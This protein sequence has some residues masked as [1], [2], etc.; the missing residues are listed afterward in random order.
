MQSSFVT[1]AF[2]AALMLSLA[3]KLWLATRQVRHVAT[4]RDRVPAAF[5]GS[6][7][8]QAHQKA[9]DY[10][11]AKGRLRPAQH[12]RRQRGA[13]GLDAARRARRAQRGLRDAV[14]PRFGAMAYQLAL[15]A[16]FAVV[17]GLLE[18]PLDWYSTFRIEQRFGFNRMTLA[19]V[20]GR[21][22]QGRCCSA[23]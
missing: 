3:V 22:A 21:H 19:P 10:T 16:T 14:L 5:A 2:A 15:L 9:A 17:G 23:R 1:L 8:L 6:V 11:L 20:A 18:L 13:A 4:H 12:R 7:T